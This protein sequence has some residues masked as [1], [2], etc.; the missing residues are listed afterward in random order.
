MIEFVNDNEYSAKIK[1]VGVGGGGTNAVNSMV[2]NNIRGVEFIVANTDLQSLENSECPEKIQIGVTLTKGLGAGSNPETGRKAA[3][4]SEDHIREMLDGADMVFITAGMGGGTGTGA[5]PIIS[6][7]AREVG[8]LTVGV[9]TKPFAFEG[10][11]RMAQAETG[12]KELKESVDTLIIIPN[13]KLLSFVGKQT[14][15]T[16]AFALVDDVLKQ[17]VCSISDLIVIPGLINLDFADVKTIMG[18]MGKAL[19]GSGVAAGESR[20]VEAA[21]KAISSPLLDE[22]TVDGAKGILINITGGE[23]LTLVEVNESSMMIQENA[24]ED[25]HIIFGAVID[26]QMEGQIRVTVIATGFE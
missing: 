26:P 13:Q 5:A 9:V 10:K 12:M 16:G 17:A 8:A 14:S 2:R 11:K 23:D 25:A 20:A 19:M 18:S 22:A 3:E 4:E 6:K 24:H 7:I 15:F 21:Q 1:V